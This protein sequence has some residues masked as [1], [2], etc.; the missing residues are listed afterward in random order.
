LMQAGY[1]TVIRS[2]PEMKRIFIAIKVD[3]EEKLDKMISYMKSEFAGEGIKW[4][5]IDNMHITLAFLGDTEIKMIKNIVS[6]LN[7]SCPAFG[8]FEITLR[9]A[10][11]FKSINDPR[12]LYAGIDHSDSLIKLNKIIIGALRD[13]GYE[14]EDRPFRP[15]LTF[16]R[17]KY[18]KDK[19]VLNKILDKYQ[20]MVFQK[21]TANEVILFESILLRTGPVYKPLARFNLQ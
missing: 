1:K 13:S 7:N 3:V 20:D 5:G 9:G 8:Q 16:G 12:I 10:G 18:I 4:T 21:V 17:V 11:A 14:I 6:K 15:H 2:K 19:Q